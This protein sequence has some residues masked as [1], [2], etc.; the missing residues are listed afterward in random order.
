MQDF[1]LGVKKNIYIFFRRYQNKHEEIGASNDVKVI[2]KSLK[3]SVLDYLLVSIE[4]HH[5][6]QISEEGKKNTEF[7]GTCVEFSKYL[8]SFQNTGQLPLLKIC[9]VQKPCQSVILVKFL[10][11]LPVMNIYLLPNGNHCSSERELTVLNS[12]F[13]FDWCFC[14]FLQ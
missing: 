7:S 14:H 9:L 5:L 11:L 6:Q 10:S 8:I 4:I 2:V 13:W 1:Y 12:L 3:I